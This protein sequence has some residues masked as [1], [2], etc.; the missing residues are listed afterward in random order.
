[1][2]I[3]DETALCLHP[4]AGRRAVFSSKKRLRNEHSRTKTHAIPEETCN[5]SCAAVICDRSDVQPLLP[6]FRDATDGVA[7]GLLLVWR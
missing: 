7:T 2:M 5:V 3:I 4:C 6:H 1:M